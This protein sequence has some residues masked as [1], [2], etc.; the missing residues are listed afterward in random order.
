MRYLGSGE[1]F[2]KIC[3]HEIWDKKTKGQKDKRTKRLKDK[4]Q[5]AAANEC[6]NCNDRRFETKIQ[7]HKNTQN[8]TQVAAGS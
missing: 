6:P 3:K 7:K 5:L 1:I 8:K 2:H 4:N